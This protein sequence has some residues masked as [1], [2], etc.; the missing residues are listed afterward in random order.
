MSGPVEYHDLD[1]LINHRRAAR[2]PTANPRRGIARLGSGPSTDDRL[3]P[4]RLPGSLDEG[5]SLLQSIFEN[6]ALVDGNKRLGW[7]AT[8]TFLEINGI[9]VTHV[10]NDAVYD[11]VIGVTIGHDDVDEIAQALHQLLAR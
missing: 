4:G 7:L 9:G 6:H 2:R 3:R 11:S 5:C 10:A 1:D 8:A